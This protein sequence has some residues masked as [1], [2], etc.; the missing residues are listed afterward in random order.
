MAYYP[1]WA[2]DD[3]PPEKIDFGR[4]DWID[5]AFAVPDKN[6]A[7]GWD[8][9]DDAPNLLRRLVARAH[10]SRKRVKLSV[11][12]WTGS[13]YF[14]A[15]VATAQS[16]ATF[17]RNLLALYRQFALDGVDI[18]WE[19]PGQP[20]AP[21][22]AVSARDTDNLLAFLTL[23]RQTLPAGAVI[24]AAAPPEPWST[25][26][27]GPAFARALDW[28]LIMNYD[29]WQASNPPGPN[30]PLSDACGNSTRPESSA[31]A[32]LR[33]WTRAGVP[34]DR[35][36]LGVPSYAYVVRSS[37][38]R[39]R[40]RATRSED[41]AP[42]PAGSHLH[43]H[44]HPHPHSPRRRRGVHAPRRPHR[45]GRVPLGRWPAGVHPTGGRRDGLL[46]L[47]RR[48]RAAARPNDDGGT[49][50]GQVQFRAL[51]AQA[52][53]SSS[54]PRP[55]SSSRKF[56]GAHGFRRTWDACSSTPFLRSAGAR[57]VVA[58]DD[59]ASL[60]VKAQFARRAGMRGVNMFD[61]H[62]D[63]DAWD[64]VDALRRGLGVTGA[65]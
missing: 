13:K 10:K 55:P 25:L 26:R 42:G 11:G 29:T 21:G 32:A 59:P 28:V 6:F 41:L 64:L 34:A 14:S 65:Q 56:A 57:Q 45:A 46:F 23:L 50:N 35:L 16:R 38:T 62:G 44:S 19:Y 12:G 58:Y 40:G 53:S 49:D 36:V 17:A 9:S 52:R 4:L 30:A 48:R 22:N 37:A 27:N 31:L 15:A 63:T 39:L 2:A 54:R 33:A 7:L 1:A 8:G 18:D 24:T 5:F 47:R 51:F 43:S 61:V 3:F 60:E 20:G